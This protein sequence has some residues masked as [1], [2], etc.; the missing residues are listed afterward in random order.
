MANSAQ[1]R[2]SYPEFIKSIAN[3]LKP[4]CEF[5]DAVAVTFLAGGAYSNN[6]IKLRVHP[7]TVQIFQALAAVLHHHNYAF[8]ETAGGTLSCRRITGGTGTS[9][10]AHGIALDINPSKNR[11]IHTALRGLI[12]WRR[13][14]DM[15]PDMITDIEGIRLA[16]G[17]HPLRWGGR[18]NN[19]KDPMHFEVQLLASELDAVNLFT[20]PFHA[21]DN[22]QAFVNQGSQPQP[23]PQGDEMLGLDIGVIG[24]PA[25]KDDMVSALQALL[26]RKGHNLGAY[27]PNK[28]GVDGIA[29]N[30]TRQALASWKT[31]NK[32]DSKGAGP[33]K[34]GPY[35]YAALLG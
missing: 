1:L 4:V 9:L 20:L 28:D 32:L 8:R 10:H 2:T 7:K 19:I 29:G 27:G 3:P 21:W 15:L 30:A 5:R 13:Q 16:N 33:G 31:A 12:Q 14:T 26:V 22:Y 34:I 6:K 35:E 11:Y 23:Q 17:K 24:S 25:V 18:W